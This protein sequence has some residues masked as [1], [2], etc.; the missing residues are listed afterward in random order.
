MNNI[1]GTGTN[2]CTAL[3]TPAIPTLK[4]PSCSR[5]NGKIVLK[6]DEK[7]LKA[8]RIAY[9]RNNRFRSMRLYA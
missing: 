8:V 9:L 5:Y 7:P 1:I 3:T 4:P 2:P 6:E